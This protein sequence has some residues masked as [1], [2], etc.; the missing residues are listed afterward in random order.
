MDW[1]DNGPLI[2]VRAIHFAATAVMTGTV[3][4]RTMARRA[5]GPG[6]AAPERFRAQSLCVV[7]IA[8]TIAVA[9]GAI[10]LLLQ[11]AAMSGLPVGEAMKPDVLSTVLSQTQFGIVTETRLGLAVVVAACLAYDR[12]ALADGFAPAAAVGLSAALAWSGHG[13][14]TPGQLGNLHLAA[15]VLHLIAAASWIGGLVPL[16]LLLV[17]AWHN[18]TVEW[19]AIARD[20]AERFSILGIVSVATLLATGIVNTW[21]LVGSFN[22]L[23]VT[24]YGQLLMLK[25]M[26]FAVM[27]AFAAV[28]RLALTPRLAG[29]PESGARIEALRRLTRNSVV[30]IALGLA[31]FAMVGMLGT[32]HPAIHLM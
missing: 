14:S 15:D 32:L 30:E 24:Q 20:S 5:L 16:V 21:I 6:R 19:A 2:G 1:L 13:G 11:A 10:W 3:V 12:P 7:W 18:P 25:I 17:L 27:L 29:S 8:L 4:F 31:I 28:N 9:S 22:A 26:V 23:F